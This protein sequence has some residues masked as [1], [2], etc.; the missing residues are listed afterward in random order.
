MTLEQKVG[1]LIQADIGSITPEDLRRYPLGAILNGGNSGPGGDD[2]APPEAWLAAA[3]AYYEAALDPGH[4]PNPIPLLWGTDAVH[5]HA[6]IRGATIFPHNLGLGA[7]GDPDL[8]RRIGEVTAR[9][10]AVTGQDWTFAPTLAVVQDVRWGRSYESYSADPN[11]VR[12]Y[13]SAMVTGLQGA[14]GSEAFLDPF[15]V[16]ATA[17]HFIGDGATGGVDQGDAAIDEETLV[18]VHN[19]GYPAAIAAGVQT[20]MVSFSSWQ[21]RK[22]HGH[23]ALLTDV[24]K[25][26]MGFDGIVVGDWNGHGQVPGCNAERCAAAIEAGVDMLM[27][28]DSWRAL[29]DNTVT[30]A[31]SGELSRARLD[32][33]VRRILRVKLRA[34][35]FTRGKPSSRPLAGQYQLLGAA[36]HRALARE[37]VRKSLVLLKNHEQLLPLSPKQRILVLGDGA[38]NRP[39]QCGGWTLSWQG[40][41]LDNGDLPGA[42]S[43][44]AGLASQVR[45]AGG[46]IELSRDGH[47]KT[48][49][50]VAIV[51]FGEDPY[52]EFVGDRDH[53]AYAPADDAHLAAMERLHK[54]GIPVVAVLLSGRPLWTNRELN[55]AD[56]F[57]A[58]WLPGSEGGGVADVLLRNRTG[59]VQ[60]DFVGRLPFPWPAQP[61]PN[62]GAGPLFAIGH[63]LGYG[64]PGELAQLPTFDEQLSALRADRLAFFVRGKPSHGLS[65]F[66][67]PKA[68]AAGEAP[69]DSRAVDQHTQEDARALTFRGPRARAGLTAM[70][71]LDLRREANGDMVLS[72]TLGLAQATPAALQ[73]ALECGDG[74]SGALPVATLHQQDDGDLHTFRVP[75]RCFAQAGADLARVSAP[76]S[77]HATGQLDLLVTDVHLETSAPLACPTPSP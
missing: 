31:R 27:A 70:A 29:F 11:R 28:P 67:A 12:A 1:Q 52:A 22:L 20:V 57:V 69:V 59:G 21:G 75:L 62:T 71:P 42:E 64:E 43:I 3:D 37:A 32:D 41:G 38:D 65:W 45:A 25:G 35:L 48:R 76:F 77:L 73:V 18:R 16:I 14:V 10:V 66:V 9:E 26:R 63:G 54:Q 7:A 6:N 39:K 8:I 13:A 24:L 74:C 5:G 61:L 60:V 17:K 68:N 15:H 58:A 36:A 40:T 49:P 33:A 53:F 4:G 44:H 2:R 19:A 56:A 46:R 47:F 51:V 23:R 50:D 55:L 72:F 34:G 30:Q